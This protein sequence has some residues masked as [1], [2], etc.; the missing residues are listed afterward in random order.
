MPAI[1]TAQMKNTSDR[2]EWYTPVRYMISVK[3][4]LGV[5]DLDPASCERANVTVAAKT[6]YTREQ[7]ALNIEWPAV[8][9]IF[10]NPPYSARII[11][12]FVEK[13]ITHYTEGKFNIG[14]VLVN[15]TTETTYWQKLAANAAKICMTNHRISF[16]DSNGMPMNQNTRG[17]TFFYFHRDAAGSAQHGTVCNFTQHFSTYGIVLSAGKE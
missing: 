11:N 17:Q 15:N 3:N 10:C 14:I 4:V 7:D 8:H 9:S 2:E 6:Y 13:I 12:Q 5:I 16:I 1:H